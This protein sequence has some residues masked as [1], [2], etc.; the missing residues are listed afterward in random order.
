MP[1]HRYSNFEYSHFR[2]YL[3]DILSFTANL[4]WEPPSA[5]WTTYYNLLHLIFSSLHQS[6]VPKWLYHE[7]C[8]CQMRLPTSLIN[9]HWLLLETQR[10]KGR[11][12]VIITVDSCV[13][14][15]HYLGHMNHRSNTNVVIPHN[16]IIQV[17]YENSI[18][19]CIA[20]K[21]GVAFLFLFS[22]HWQRPDTFSFYQPPNLRS[23][24]GTSA[25]PRLSGNGS[26]VNISSGMSTYSHIAGSLHWQSIQYSL[27][28]MYGIDIRHI[29]II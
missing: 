21:I 3:I 8:L 9:M 29:L 2:L 28:C 20:V 23:F 25:A 10:D 22:Y 27:R 16:L 15:I 4:L 26:P 19:P 12:S 5:R 6:I 24:G 11:S 13:L 1:L 17:L 14:H 7:R 18:D